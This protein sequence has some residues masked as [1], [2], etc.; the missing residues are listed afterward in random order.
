MQKTLWGLL[1]WLLTTMAYAQTA[2]STR[3]YRHHIGLNT[4][5]AQDQFFNP[6]AR[7]PLQIMYKR[8]NKGNSAWR[9]GMGLYYNY[10]DSTYDANRFTGQ[11][12][13]LK[14]GLS[15]GYEWQHQ[16]LPK[17]IFFYGGDLA[18]DIY[19]VKS[20]GRFTSSVIL[21]GF[22]PD[23]NGFDEYMHLD[24][25]FKPFIGFR[26]HLSKR[27]Y[28]AYEA[29]VQIRHH[30]Y[31]NSLRTSNSRTSTTRTFEFT[32]TQFAFQAYSGVYLFYQF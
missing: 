27:L 3:S 1:L 22:S 16:V 17:T 28:L 2:D 24:L 14:T 11:V 10:S 9:V 29:N 4:Q 31:S 30:R 20:Q 13:W 19:Y 26:Y 6:N 21:P 15:L 5:F 25:M 32:N 7:T 12:I 8:Q 18:S 23:E